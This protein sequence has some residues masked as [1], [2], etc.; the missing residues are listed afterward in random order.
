MIVRSTWTRDRNCF[1]TGPARTTADGRPRNVRRRTHRSQRAQSER[2][3]PTRCCAPANSSST[4][5]CRQ[6][7]APVPGPITE[8]RSPV[9]TQA[10]RRG[11]KLRFRLAKS[12]SSPLA[13]IC[14]GTTPPPAAAAAGAASSEDPPAAAAK[15]GATS[16]ARGTQRGGGGGGALRRA[17]AQGW[18]SASARQAA[19]R[20][21]AGASASL[22]LTHG[23]GQ[24]APGSAAALWTLGLARQRGLAPRRPHQAA[25]TSGHRGSPSWVIQPSN[26]W[27]YPSPGPAA[28]QAE[29]TPAGRG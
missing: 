15:K 4:Q 20:S 23:R 11:Q 19:G 13:R 6:E 29:P 27:V 12:T 25:D 24:P 26:R 3:S 18:G 10:V 21:G 22:K 17:V 14:S 16:A 9:P 28:E 5:S 2:R 8:S 7:L 1:A